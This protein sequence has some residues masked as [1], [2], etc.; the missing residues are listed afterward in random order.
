M[1]AADVAG[2]T[3][4]H[5]TVVTDPAMEVDYPNWY[6]LVTAVTDC[7]RHGEVKIRPR[8]VE[9]RIL[10]GSKWF[11]TR[12]SRKELGTCV[13]AHNTDSYRYSVVQ[14]QSS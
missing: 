14:D 2:I 10:Y 8:A 7:R 3:Y 5:V 1:F 4:V 11:G 6:S 9:G 13:P 12:S